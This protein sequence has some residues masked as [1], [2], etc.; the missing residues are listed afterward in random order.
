MQT[1]ETITNVQPASGLHQT[2]SL[3]QSFMLHKGLINKLMDEKEIVEFLNKESAYSSET[4]EDGKISDKSVANKMIPSKE[5]KNKRPH[6]AQQPVV[7]G[8]ESLSSASEVTI[9][10]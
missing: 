4:T 3:M 2:L 6:K 10:K 8:G 5:P 9:Y 1:N 7:T